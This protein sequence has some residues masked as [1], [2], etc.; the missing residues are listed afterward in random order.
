M[1]GKTSNSATKRPIPQEAF[2]WYDEYAHGKIDRREFLNRLAGLA[3]LG[4][5]V[6]TL[7]EALLPD[8]AKAEQVS[9][10][11]PDIKA[12]YQTFPSPKGHGEGK[13]YLVVPTQL[14]TPLPVVLVVHENRGLNPYIKDV[15]RRLA[16]QGFV[17]FAPDALAPVG[18]YPGNDDQGR[19]LQ[20]NLDRA[21]I[22]QDFIAAAQYLKTHTLSNGKLGA[23]GFCFGGYVVNMLAAV[24]GEQLNAGVP[25]YG[26]PAEKSLRADIKA[27]LQLHFAELDQRVNATWPDYEQDLKAINARYNAFIYP[28]VNH[29]FHNDSTARYA[30][31]EAELAWQRTVE[32]FRRELKS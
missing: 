21:K 9:F 19:E 10:N 23:V 25:F 17:A 4:F 7:T 24:M 30:P 20:K 22:E 32:F 27:P 18:G 13:G 5:S 6:A 2:D 1:V 26:T 8:Y 28:K 12:S 11:D 3:V 31:E 29:G 14:T 16:K 15:A